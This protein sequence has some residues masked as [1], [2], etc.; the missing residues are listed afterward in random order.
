MI[1]H[2]DLLVLYTIIPAS[3]LFIISLVLSII[4]LCTSSPYC[5]PILAIRCKMGNVVESQVQAIV[6]QLQEFVNL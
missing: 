6:C 2:N 4:L 1:L 5:V 3:V